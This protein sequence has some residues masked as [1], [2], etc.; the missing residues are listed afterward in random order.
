MSAEE[1]KQRLSRIEQV[2]Q[3]NGS[4]ARRPNSEVDLDSSSAISQGLQ[5][6]GHR[7][8]KVKRAASQVFL[9]RLIPRN[10]S[11]HQSRNTVDV[12]NRNIHTSWRLLYKDWFHGEREQGESPM[13]FI[14]I[15]EIR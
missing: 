14:F 11:F 13:I 3:S 15:L 5:H 9:P 4:D 12:T 8:K 7:K 6:S 2:L 10:F 1:P